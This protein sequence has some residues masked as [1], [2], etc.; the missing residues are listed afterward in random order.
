VHERVEKVRATLLQAAAILS[1]A[2]VFAIGTWA[3]LTF[4]IKWL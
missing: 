3:I 1:I 4:G 2:V